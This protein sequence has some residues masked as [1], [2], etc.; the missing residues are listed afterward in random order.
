MLGAQ[1]EPAV[2]HRERPAI[3][4]ARDARSSAKKAGHR[5]NDVVPLRCVFGLRP[6]AR[7]VHMAFGRPP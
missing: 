3:I 7:A 2:T 6:P 1:T 4:M 5:Q